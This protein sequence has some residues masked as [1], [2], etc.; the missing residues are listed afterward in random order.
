MVGAK[1]KALTELLLAG[2]EV[3]PIVRRRRSGHLH[4][5]APFLPGL[6]PGVCSDCG[7]WKKK[8]SARCLRCAHKAQIKPRRCAEC[9]GV[10]KWRKE[11]QGNTCCSEA[12]RTARLLKHYLSNRVDDTEKR[13]RKRAHQKRV[14]QRRKERGW[15]R[16]DGRWMAVCER[17]GWVC[18]VCHEPIDPA[19]TRLDRLSGTVDHVIP[20]SAGGSDDDHNLRAAH[21]SCNVRRWHLGKTA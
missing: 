6:F 5:D 9:A 13:R 4:Q 7:G 17:D 15:R 21:L 11:T 20:I 8:H 1:P 16:K 10:F 12:C 14:N 2:R 19:R 3:R 18:W